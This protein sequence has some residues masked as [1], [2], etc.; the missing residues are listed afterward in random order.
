MTTFFGIHIKMIMNN[1]KV[2]TET[3]LM[4]ALT[5]QRFKKFSSLIMLHT[6]KQHLTLSI[7][8]SYRTTKHDKICMYSQS[9]QVLRSLQKGARKA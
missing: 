9:K 6:F 1:Q 7:L 2:P 5:S 8:H 3:D 4:S